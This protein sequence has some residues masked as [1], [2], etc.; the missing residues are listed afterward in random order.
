MRGDLC[1]FAFLPLLIRVVQ[2][3]DP[4]AFSA[5]LVCFEAI[6][7]IFWWAIWNFIP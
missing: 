1:N 6:F 3:R 5:C 2:N 7:G 4:S